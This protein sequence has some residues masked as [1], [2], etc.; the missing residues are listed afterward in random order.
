LRKF[1]YTNFGSIITLIFAWPLL[2]VLWLILFY[3]SVS[4][5]PLNIGF[6]LLGG[7]FL[8]TN[9]TFTVP[10]VYTLLLWLTGK[11]IEARIDKGL[12]LLFISF[13]ASVYLFSRIFTYVALL[14]LIGIFYPA[15]FGL[16]TYKLGVLAIDA[17][18]LTGA[19]IGS[20]LVSTFSISFLI[21][22]IIKRGKKRATH[23]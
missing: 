2:T 4:L 10:I 14:F 19:F 7:K 20:S 3:I 22:Y 12:P 17:L 21:C 9:Y 8:W 16:F 13:Q 23:N 5:T 1:F 15:K 11:K 6:I 18:I